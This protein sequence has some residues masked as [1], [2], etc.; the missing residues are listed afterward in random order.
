VAKT[1][2]KHTQQLR[3]SL[4]P[5][6]QEGD[7]VTP[8]IGLEI[9][10]R[11]CG[12]ESDSIELDVVGLAHFMHLKLSTVVTS[13]EK[14]SRTGWLTTDVQHLKGM[15]KRELRLGNSNRVAFVRYPNYVELLNSNLQ[16][17]N[18]NKELEEEV[19]I[20][21]KKNIL[22]AAKK[23]PQVQVLKP[24]ENPKV[25]SK[26]KI[27]EPEKDERR[28]IR[29]FWY[30]RYGEVFGH[31]YGEPLNKKIHSQ[32]K[33]IH[34]RFGTQRATELID[35]YFA[36][37][38]P[39]ALKEGHS[40]GLF[41]NK[42]PAMEASF[43]RGDVIAK[44]ADLSREI[45]KGYENDPEQQFRK[46]QQRKNQVNALTGTRSIEEVPE[47]PKPRLSRLTNGVSSSVLQS[48]S[49]EEDFECIRDDEAEYAVNSGS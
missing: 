25:N 43:H 15:S 28:E 37:R 8:I 49:G 42:I 40:L 48:R 20:E 47:P 41:M 5:F 10:S 16:N 4:I 11:M 46:Y 12:K 9:L 31:A 44:Q 32:F 3:E 21:K 29:E 6:Y 7:F 36:W 38:D 19:D 18:K 30:R 2:F 27:I 45:Q 24:I 26:P 13:L 17:K 35:R 33:I 1:W 39:Y 14:L 34:E 22:P 23:L